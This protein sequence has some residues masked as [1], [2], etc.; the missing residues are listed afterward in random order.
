MRLR[1]PRPECIP[2]TSTDSRLVLF[3]SLVG[4]RQQAD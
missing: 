3:A 4:D 2:V 1:K